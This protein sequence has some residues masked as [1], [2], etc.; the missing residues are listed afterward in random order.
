MKGLVGRVKSF[1]AR[2]PVPID[3]VITDDD[4]DIAEA[5]RHAT[6]IQSWTCPARQAARRQFGENT[7]VGSRYVQVYEDKELFTLVAVFD[8]GD[9]L[10]AFTKQF[11]YGRTP[12]EPIT[13]RLRPVSLDEGRNLA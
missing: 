10:A 7:I 9:E 6:L 13:I 5:V 1:F 11:D 3:L 4:V 2:P 8:G 12:V